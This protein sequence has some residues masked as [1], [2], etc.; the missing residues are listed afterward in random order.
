[1]ALESGL[2]WDKKNYYSNGEYF[3]KSKTTIPNNV[4]INLDGYCNMFE[5]PLNFRYD[6]AARNNHNFFATAGL[7]SYIMKKEYYNYKAESYYLGTRH[8]IILTDT[9]LFELA[10]IISFLSCS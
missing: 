8:I 4:N 7:S 2:I 6:F 5:I 3:D 9:I 1:M 10:T